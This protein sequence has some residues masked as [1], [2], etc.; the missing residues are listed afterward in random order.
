MEVNLK[1]LIE[2]CDSEL[3]LE[4][5]VVGNRAVRLTN[6]KILQSPGLAVGPGP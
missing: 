4:A 3:D 5:G 1:I 6:L 2:D